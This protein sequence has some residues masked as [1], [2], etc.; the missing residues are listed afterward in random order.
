[1][2]KLIATV[3]TVMFFTAQPCWADTKII[4]TLVVS[5]Q[6]GKSLVEDGA[7]DA[8]MS[9]ASTFKI[10][11][12]LM[13][14]DAGILQTAQQ[15]V[16]PFKEGYL[17]GRPEWRRSQTPQSWMRESVIWYSQQITLRL[18]AE[19]FD[20]YVR[21][22]EYGN[23]DASGQPGKRD[24]LT[25][26][27]LSS[28]LQISPREQVGFLG[29]LLRHELPVSQGAVSNTRAILD[30]GLKGQWRVFGKTGAGGARGKD[31]K[32]KPPLFGW[33]VGWAE[34]GNETV[35]FA[36]LIEDSERQPTPSGFRARDGLMQD[37][38]S[39]NGALE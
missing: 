33:F 39:T 11:I 21:A 30:Q 26:A 35:L 17:D 9:P 13:G 10:A 37:L 8:R 32:L 19:K 25:H 12:S 36:R 18:G 6:T 3:F 29:K 27:W 20:A 4:C 31:G 7:C 24:G 38:F 22:F 14:F 1:M 5:A 16:W 34:K 28:S 23:Q 2:K 15:P